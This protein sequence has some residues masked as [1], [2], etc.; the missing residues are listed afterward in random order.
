MFDICTIGHI[1]TDKVVTAQTTKYLPGGTSFYFSRLILYSDLRYRLITA[2]APE[3][4]H[5]VHDLRAA[6]VDVCV[7]PST[8]TVFF[9]NIYSADQ[10]HRKQHVLHQASPFHISELP[11]TQARIFHLG[12]LLADDI[13]VAMIE[14]LSKI[15]LVSL[16]IQG[17]L[18]HVSNKKVIH[19]DWRDKITALPHV[20]ILKAN[21]FEMQVLTGKTNVWDGAKYLADLGVPEVVLTLGSKG[22]I[23]YKSGI[24]YNIPAFKP[25]AVIDATGCGDTYMAAYLW[26]RIKGTEVQEAG[27]FGAALATL[28]IG[29][30]GPFSG[31]SSQISKLLEKVM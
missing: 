24:F 28:K 20:G 30:F 16:D 19:L 10:D 29:S 17:Y 2:L 21:E 15:G 14:H 27:E 25:A 6:G 5:T 11:Q 8:Q 3:D 4:F 12:P 18:R 13:P 7:L 31:P 26:M 1:S 22:S 23:I 9:E